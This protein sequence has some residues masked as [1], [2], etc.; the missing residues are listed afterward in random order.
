MY[1]FVFVCLRGFLPRVLATLI[2]YSHSEVSPLYP[3]P[4]INTT[5]SHCDRMGCSHAFGMLCFL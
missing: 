2:K 4:I 5:L 1:A 3:F